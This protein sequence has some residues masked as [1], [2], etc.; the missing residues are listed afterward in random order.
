MAKGDKAADA[1][2]TQG[3]LDETGEG[4]TWDMTNTEAEDGYPVLPKANYDAIVDSC[5][6][7]K[8]KNS[9]KPMWKMGYL[10]TEAEHASKNLKVFSYQVFQ[11]DQMGR[12]K[13]LLENLGHGN[14]AT[15][16]FNPKTVADDKVLV[17]SPCKLKLDIRESDEYG[18]SNEVKRV[19]KPGTGGGAAAGEGGFQL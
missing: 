15:P 4:F 14:L 13:A 12:V 7:Q 5:E 10:I 16:D 2:A 3:V 9:G 18:N 1:A 6:Y 19:M 8:S 17:G 11:P